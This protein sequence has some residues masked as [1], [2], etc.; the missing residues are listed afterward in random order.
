MKSRTSRSG[1][2]AKLY[3]DLVDIFLSLSLPLFPFVR[4]E[5]L[6]ST[7]FPPHRAFDENKFQ[8]VLCSV[9]KT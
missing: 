2:A 6:P 8:F 7:S 4:G 3:S 5:A 1:D 9:I